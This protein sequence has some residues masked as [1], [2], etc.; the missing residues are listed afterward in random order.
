MGSN[1]KKLADAAC[2]G[3]T[4]HQTKPTIQT[5]SK[6]QIKKS[7]SERELRERERERTERAGKNV[8]KWPDLMR[9]PLVNLNMISSSLPSISGFG[10]WSVPPNSAESVKDSELRRLLAAHIERLSVCMVRLGQKGAARSN[11]IQ[12]MSGPYRLTDILHMLQTLLKLLAMSLG[13][14]RRM[15]P[16]AVNHFSL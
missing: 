16:N 15:L 11:Q 2:R 9:S 10:Q 12:P 1:L 7:E 3:Q 6:Q 4:L 5:G 8:C 14:G 13:K